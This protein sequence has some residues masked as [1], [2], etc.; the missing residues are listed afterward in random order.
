MR[1]SKINARTIKNQYLPIKNQ[2]MVGSLYNCIIKNIPL[3][4]L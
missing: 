4:S 2:F 3:V 1:N